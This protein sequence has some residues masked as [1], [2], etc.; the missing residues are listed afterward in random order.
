MSSS[1]A[2][3]LPEVLDFRPEEGVI[4]LHEQRVV[5]LSAAALGLLRK[6]L[7]ATL[8]TDSARRLLLRFGYADG[9]HDA[10]SL[11]DRLRWRE[12]L[13]GFRA[14]AALHTLEGIV[15]AEINRAEHNPANSRF[16]AEIT[17]HHSYEAEQHLH[18]HGRSD[19]PVCWSLLGYVSGFAS[20][21]IGAEIYF[22][23]RACVGCGDAAC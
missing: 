23:E 10:V 5:I 16:D 6:E 7:V 14:G 15:R 13:E 1:R 19:S 8:G 3:Q 11:R 22:K 17:W 9:Y 4:R 20:A 21:C 2:L 18:H 12:P